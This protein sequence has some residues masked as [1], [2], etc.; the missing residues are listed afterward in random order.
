MNS[1]QKKKKKKEGSSQDELL[2]HSIKPLEV[3][4]L[5]FINLCDASKDI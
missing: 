4:G 2:L 3:P 5:E 1:E